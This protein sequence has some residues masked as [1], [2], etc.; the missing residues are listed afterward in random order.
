MIFTEDVL[1]AHLHAHW[2]VHNAA[3][4]VL[5]QDAGVFEQVGALIVPKER[6]F[7]RE[8]SPPDLPIL[9]T[10]HDKMDRQSRLEALPLANII[11]TAMRGCNLKAPGYAVSLT[12]VNQT[13]AFPRGFAHYNRVLNDDTSI[14]HNWGASKRNLRIQLKQLAAAHPG[15]PPAG[16]PL[17]G[18]L[19]AHEWPDRW[20]QMYPP[21]RHNCGHPEHTN[22]GVPQPQF[23]TVN[24]AQN[25]DQN[26]FVRSI[27]VYVSAFTAPCPEMFR[28]AIH[29]PA[30]AGA[31][32][33]EHHHIYF[34][35][36]CASH[37]LDWINV[38]GPPNGFPNYHFHAVVSSQTLADPARPFHKNSSNAISPMTRQ[39]TSY[40]YVHVYTG[41]MIVERCKSLVD[42]E[43]YTSL[44][45]AAAASSNETIR[46][47][48]PVKPL[49]S[50][51]PPYNL[52]THP[53]PNTRVPNEW[54]FAPAWQHTSKDNVRFMA[55]K[56]NIEVDKVLTNQVK[57]NGDAQTVFFTK[58]IADPIGSAFHAPP[59]PGHWE[60]ILKFGVAIPAYTN[61][62]PD[63]CS[64]NVYFCSQDYPAIQ[65]ALNNGMNCIL[66]FQTRE[67][68]VFHF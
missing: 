20:C 42:F 64:K 61:D 47:F 34:V 36:D 35:M 33:G 52:P 24:T 3:S 55:K 60:H 17:L 46:F 37:L 28:G 59:D 40:K 44:T 6:T 62:M 16:I 7:P 45:S 13:T 5:I 41:D 66:I 12:T 53:D 21:V 22:Q 54:R 32:A 10:V 8:F 9:E 58:F 49:L 31:P 56:T 26:R 15:P 2:N 67:Y 39:P 63:L 11:S 1:V 51:G 23:K 19:H 65:L 57:R 30:P 25:P 50:S 14:A 27:P 38:Y 4:T 18:Q 29:S 68:I 48:N 43:I